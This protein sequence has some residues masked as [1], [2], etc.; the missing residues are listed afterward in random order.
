M[1]READRI[2]K[3]YF[4]QNDR[5]SDLVNFTLYNGKEVTKPSDFITLDPVISEVFS[6]DKSY[7]VLI[8][9]L[10]ELSL[11][12]DDRNIYAMI[13]LEVQGYHDKSMVLRAMRAKSLLYTYQFRKGEKPLKPVIIIV[14]N[15]TGRR[16]RSPVTL[17]SMFEKE[18]LDKFGNLIDDVSYVLLDIKEDSS[19]PK[20]L[21]KTDLELLLNCLKFSNNKPKL[22]EYIEKEKGF[23]SLDDITFKLIN[24]LSVLDVEIKK[25]GGKI[26]MWPAV[27]Q[28]KEESFNSGADYGA[29]KF[30]DK[31]VNSNILTID[32]AAR[33]LNLT[34]EEYL[35]AVKNLKK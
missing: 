21:L 19:I 29:L 23:N 28:M 32:Q 15:L 2:C 5:F 11:K 33:E 1:A 13:G 7:E 10:K 22:E 17:K 35:A 24:K 8:D 3:E 12:E 9:N 27:K 30:A 25:E 31:M 18:C 6:S 14:F 20:G 4:D 16:W 26:N 34:V